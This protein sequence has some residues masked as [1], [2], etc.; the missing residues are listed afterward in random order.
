MVSLFDCEYRV[1]FAG[2]SSRRPVLLD[3]SVVLQIE[4]GE[5]VSLFSRQ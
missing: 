1:V 4:I 5:Q 2:V 3:P